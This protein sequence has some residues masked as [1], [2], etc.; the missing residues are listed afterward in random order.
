MWGVVKYSKKGGCPLPTP[1]NISARN[2]WFI[3][4]S[5]GLVEFKAERQ[6]L[7]AVW[8]VHSA[9]CLV[10]ATST[11]QALKVCTYTYI[12]THMYMYMYMYVCI[13]MYV[14]NERVC[15]TISGLKWGIRRDPPTSLRKPKKYVGGGIF[16]V[17]R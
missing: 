10:E 4:V 2:F 12:Y 8:Q 6:A 7:K 11:C 17:V 1:R 5:P 14:Q 3:M 16:H 13:C 15:H 9:Q